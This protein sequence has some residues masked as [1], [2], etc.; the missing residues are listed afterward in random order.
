MCPS[1]KAV[2][3]TLKFRVVQFSGTHDRV[4]KLLHVRKRPQ[5]ALFRAP[6]KADAVKFFVEHVPDD[7]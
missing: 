6:F 5:S 4:R 2:D 3:K 1:S 7:E